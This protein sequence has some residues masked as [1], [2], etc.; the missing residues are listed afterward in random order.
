MDIR[1]I[2]ELLGHESL[3]TT[4]IYDAGGKLI[5][6]H[7]KYPVDTGGQRVEDEE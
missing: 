1:Y 2:Q 3:A 7:Q 4:E 5:A 6:V